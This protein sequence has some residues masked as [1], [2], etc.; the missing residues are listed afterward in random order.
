MSVKIAFDSS[1][2]TSGH[3]VRGIGAY[4]KNLVW[5][6]EQEAKRAGRDWK[7]DF[8]DLTNHQSLITN[9]DLIHYPYFD[10]FSPTLPI[11]KITKTVV[12]IHDV[13]PLVFP[14]HYPPGLRGKVK[15]L[16]QKFSLRSVD[17]VITDS[18]NSQK[19]IIEYLG[20]PENKIHVIY[21]APAAIFKPITDHQSLV[22][23]GKKY[24]LPEKFV[25]YVGDVNWNKNVLG[26]AQACKK[27]GVPL[28]IVGK[29]AAQTNFDTGHIENR[30]LVQLIKQ[31]GKDHDILRLGFVDEG[32]LVKIYNLA[33]VYCQPSFYEGF[34]LPVL[35]A[36]VCGCPVVAANTSSLP[37]IC[38]EAAVMVDPDDYND[39]AKGLDKVISDK[40]IR[41]MLI[42]KGL[43]QVKKFSWE[44]VAQET[45]KVYEK[46][47]KEK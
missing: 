8:V 42:R 41:D 44:K 31:Y 7:I 32:D 21:L 26:L 37:E 34:G 36:M 28:V 4:T 16:I 22:T 19:D 5:W 6:L 18:K 23:V 29:Q 15:F 43:I 2:L 45:F 27:I 33:T 25:L 9:Y 11:K 40:G 13:I 12:T 46:V 30:P 10:L 20:Y 1:P 17:A 39:I 3:A 38:G 24:N 47:V 35:E 14:Q